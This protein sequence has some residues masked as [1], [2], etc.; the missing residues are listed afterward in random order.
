MKV[1]IVGTASGFSVHLNGPKPSNTDEN[2]ARFGK[3]LTA[4][5]SI[6]FIN[7]QIYQSQLLYSHLVKSY[8]GDNN[9]IDQHGSTCFNR[10]VS[11]VV[12]DENLYQ[13]K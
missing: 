5:T 8:Q 9:I 4:H 3:M 13:V 7:W 1:K 11:S 6:S 12:I 10:E 2:K